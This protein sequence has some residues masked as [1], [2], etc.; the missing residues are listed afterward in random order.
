ME[1]AIIRTLFG[2]LAAFTISGVFSLVR[3]M[4]RRFSYRRN[5]GS[6]SR[7]GSVRIVRSDTGLPLDTLRR[8]GV[9]MVVSTQIGCATIPCSQSDQIRK[10]IVGL[11]AE[12]DDPAITIDRAIE[13]AAKIEN[14]SESAK[15]CGLNWPN[16]GRHESNSPEN[17]AN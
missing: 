8:L 12:L 1:N 4:L 3:W 14:L 16:A 7:P 10:E 15:K 11:I 9:I 17:L 6:A 5:S 13:I 2:I